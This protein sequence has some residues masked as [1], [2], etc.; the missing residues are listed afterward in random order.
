VAGFRYDDPF[1]RQAMAMLHH[2]EP[3]LQPT[4]QSLFYRT[5]HRGRRL[6]S[7]DYDHTLIATQVIPTPADD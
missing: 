6:S 7:P 1:R 3:A 4:S 5:G 2:D